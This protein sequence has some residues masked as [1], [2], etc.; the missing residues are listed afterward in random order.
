MVASEQ[1][2]RHLEPLRVTCGPECRHME[3]TVTVASLVMSAPMM[4]STPTAEQQSALSPASPRQQQQQGLVFRQRQRSAAATRRAAKL[5]LSQTVCAEC[6]RF[7][8][9]SAVLDA[10]VQHERPT[11]SSAQ[12]SAEMSAVESVAMRYHRLATMLVLQLGT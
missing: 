12:P 9:A 2:R 1:N 6:L 7:V 11:P 10:R 3:S 4:W 5:H 8:A